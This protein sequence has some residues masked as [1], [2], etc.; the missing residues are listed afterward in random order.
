MKI[1]INTVGATVDRRNAKL[2][3]VRLARSLQTSNAHNARCRPGAIRAAM[4]RRAVTMHAADDDVT[5]FAV[6]DVIA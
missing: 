5:T 6:I 1:D 2:N 4:R 3:Y